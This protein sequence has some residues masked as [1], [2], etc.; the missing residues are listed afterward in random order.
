MTHVTGNA[1]RT[2]T[3]WWIACSCGAKLGPFTT[4]AQAYAADRASKQMRASDYRFVFDSVRPHPDGGN[5][6]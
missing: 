5:G 3:G 6:R 2:Q 1:I 4:E